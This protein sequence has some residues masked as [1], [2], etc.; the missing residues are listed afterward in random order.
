VFYTVIMLRKA[1]LARHGI[2]FDQ[3]SLSRPYNL[4][5]VGA[6]VKPCSINQS[7]S[8]HLGQG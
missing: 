2:M 7:I 5:C 8:L 3:F 4:Y 6:D 1:H